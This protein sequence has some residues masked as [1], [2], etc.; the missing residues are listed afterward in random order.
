MAK[1]FRFI[2]LVS[3]SRAHLVQARE[4][5][6]E[7][8]RFASTVGAMLAAAGVAC[9]LHA[10]VPAVCT[11]TASRTISQL[12]ALLADRSMLPLVAREAG[13][14]T[15]FALLLA[16]CLG[17]LLLLWITGAAAL[18]ALPMSLIAL[19][20]PIAMLC[21]NPELQRLEDAALA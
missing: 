3:G 7:H 8:L 17:A 4:S 1:G 21:T 19:A 18:V 13:E 20:M 16:L 12:N 14:A 5:Y 15:A 6:F 10:I 9:T 2:P 11:S